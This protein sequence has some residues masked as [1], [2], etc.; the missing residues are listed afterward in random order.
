MAQPIFCEL[1]SIAIPGWFDEDGNQI[2][3]A[4]VEIADAP[5]AAPK[6]ESKQQGYMKTLERAWWAAGGEEREGKPYVSRAAVRA[7][8]EKDGTAEKTIR[9]KLEPGRDTGIIHPLLNSG[10]IEPIE[11]GWI[12]TDNLIAAAL[13]L[14]KNGG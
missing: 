11:H 13:L 5:P 14:R 10:Q 6:K 9:N 12:I 7:L 3:S 1:R 4:I 2:T 8:L